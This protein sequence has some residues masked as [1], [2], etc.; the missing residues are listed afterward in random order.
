MCLPESLLALVSRD[1]PGGH[2]GE[3][4]VELPADRPLGQHS[5]GLRYRWQPIKPAALHAIWEMRGIDGPKGHARYRSRGLRDE[6]VLSYPVFFFELA[7][8]F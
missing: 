6:D 3:W 1:E 8:S 2:A 5:G 7:L 4:C